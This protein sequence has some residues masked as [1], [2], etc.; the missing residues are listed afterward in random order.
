MAEVTYKTLRYAQSDRYI[1]IVILM[2]EITKN[3]LICYSEGFLYKDPQM[4][5]FT[6]HDM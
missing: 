3:L 2:N 1:A 4:L 6:Q 5:S